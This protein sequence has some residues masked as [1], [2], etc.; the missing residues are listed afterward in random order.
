M[1]REVVPF[2]DALHHRGIGWATGEGLRELGVGH[3]K[4]ARPL[5]LEDLRLLVAEAHERVHGVRRRVAAAGGSKATIYRYFDSKEA[6]FSAIVDELQTV[7]GKAPPAADVADLALSEG[8]RVLARATTDAALSERA[9]VLLR[10]AIGEH[11]RF[12]EL[13]RQ[14]FDLA[15]RRSYERFKAF[16]AAKAERGEVNVPDP[17]IAAEHFLAGL[18]GHLQ[19]GT[20]LGV[21]HPTAA[22][23]DRRIEATVA[24][25]M[26]TYATPS[27]N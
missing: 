7:T 8:L 23:A 10:L 14:L 2:R 12:P 6:L 9:I 17:Q 4:A 11:N 18:V 13:A 27:A 20:L 16:L 1:Q 19:L 25:F 24:M 21:Y 22:D 3:V 26:A 5:E 15:P